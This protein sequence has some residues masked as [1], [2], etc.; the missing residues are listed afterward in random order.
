MVSQKVVVIL[1][2]I[3]IILSAVSIVVTVST[4]NNT[5]VPGPPKINIEHGDVTSDAEKAQM[6]ITI[7]P[8]PGGGA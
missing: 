8:P 2:T 5:M 4:L 1:I 3:A 7:S 6:S